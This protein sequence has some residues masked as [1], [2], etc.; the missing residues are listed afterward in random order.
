MKSFLDK[1]S[2]IHQVSCPYTP[3]Q[4]GLAE[5]KHRHMVE[6]ALNLMID[7]SILATLWYHT[8]SYVA[9]LINRM[10]CKVLDN[11]SPYQMLF[12]ENP[13]IHSLK[14]FGTAIYPYLRPYNTN[15]LQIK[16][17]QFVFLGFAIGY[18]GVIWL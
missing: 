15:K 3:Q 12:G 16:S 9:F 2:V 7:V 13:T 10:P 1:K 14:V 18:K 11:R 8:W 6:T 4:N 17:S 5:R